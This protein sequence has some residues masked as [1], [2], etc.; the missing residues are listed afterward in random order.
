MIYRLPTESEA[1]AAAATLLRC[2]GHDL[3]VWTGGNWPVDADDFLKP[4]ASRK[5]VQP[6]ESPTKAQRAA[7]VDALELVEQR[8]P[9]SFWH[10][11]KG[12]VKAEEPLY[13]IQILFGT[14]DVLAEGEGN[15]EAEAILAALGGAA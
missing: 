13:A 14:D 4:I 10:I 5:A 11:A 15:T 6:N 8:F 7:F 9:G 3:D 1:G 2:N 12:R